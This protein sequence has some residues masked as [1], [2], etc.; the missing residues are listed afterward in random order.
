MGG[1]IGEGIVKQIADGQMGWWTDGWTI[2]HYS[3]PLQ[4]K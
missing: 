4:K 1:G 2:D 3:C